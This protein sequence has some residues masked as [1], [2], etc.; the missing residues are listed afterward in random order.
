VVYVPKTFIAEANKFVNQYIENLL[1]F[2]G[3]SFGF[4]YDINGNNN[5]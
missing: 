3:V 5:Y 1:M 4:S 2:R